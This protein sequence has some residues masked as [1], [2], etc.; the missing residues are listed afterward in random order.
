MQGACSK[1]LPLK[2]SGN[3]QAN[4]QRGVEDVEV[5]MHTRT[6]EPRDIGSKG[7]SLSLVDAGAGAEHPW[8]TGPAWSLQNDL[9]Q[10]PH[11]TGRKSLTPQCVHTAPIV[12]LKAMIVAA[13]HA[14]S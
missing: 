5:G 8:A 4:Q 14:D 13:D 1:G 6:V 10:G 2:S 3:N 9:P 12:S 11:T 7:T